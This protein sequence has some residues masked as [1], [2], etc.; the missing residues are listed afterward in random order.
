MFVCVD[1]VPKG[2]F[3]VEDVTAKLAYALAT[4]GREEDFAEVR[5]LGA[6]VLHDT[7]LD[8][9]GLMLDAL[10][11]AFLHD[12]DLERAASLFKASLAAPDRF[13]PKASTQRKL[14][15]VNGN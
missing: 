10:G 13:W 14:E 15:S 4:R 6:A 5:R 1:A 3:D 12:G 8:R 2:G 7:R 11:T 9:R